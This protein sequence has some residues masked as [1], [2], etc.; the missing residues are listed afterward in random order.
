MVYE[1]NAAN[2]TETAK[3]LSVSRQSLYTWRDAF[4][5]LNEKMTDV[6][7][8]LLDL[9]ESKLLDAIRKGNLTAIIFHLKTKGKDR[10][11][12]ERTENRHDAEITGKDGKDLLCMK[13]DEEL[14]NEI[15]ELKRKLK[16]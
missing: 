13:S 14:Q 2:L 12:V 8:G 6:E 7:E 4:P 1:N 16:G 5:L 9:S 3:A 15:E 11:Y 10:G